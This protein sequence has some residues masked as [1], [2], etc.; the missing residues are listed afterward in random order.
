METRSSS[1]NC[2]QDGKF[3]IQFLGLMT[4]PSLFCCGIALWFAC[5][6]WPD[7]HSGIRPQ[8]SPQKFWRVRARQVVRD[9]SLLMAAHWASAPRKRP[10][11]SPGDDMGRATGGQGASSVGAAERLVL[12]GGGTASA[13]RGTVTGV[14]GGSAIAGADAGTGDGTEAA[15]AARARSDSM[16]SSTGSARAGACSAALG[17]SGTGAGA[18]MAGLWGVVEA[19][20]GRPTRYQAAAPATASTAAAAST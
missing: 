9:N 8:A 2:A 14:K 6:H 12:L 18:A 19:A 20:S 17:A 16:I 15:A 5:A 11:L 10:R 7:G 3:S 1:Y 13:T 4:F